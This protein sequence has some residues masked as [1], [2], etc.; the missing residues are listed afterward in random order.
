M[1]LRS[2]N[3]ARSDARRNGEQHHEQRDPTPGR[4]H[5]RPNSCTSPIVAQ[6]E[7]AISSPRDG[8]SETRLRFLSG[9]TNSKSG[10]TWTTTACVLTQA[11]RAN[12]GPCLV[13]RGEKGK[14]P[15]GGLKCP[16]LHMSRSASAKRPA[17]TRTGT[18]RPLLCFV[19][20]P[21]QVRRAVP[22]AFSP[23][24]CNGGRTIRAF[25]IQ[26]INC[27]ERPDLAEKLGAEDRPVIGRRREPEGARP[28]GRRE[29]VQ[30]HRAAARAVARRLGRF[31]RRRRPP[32]LRSPSRTRRRTSS[33]CRTPTRTRA[34]TTTGRGRRRPRAEAFAGGTVRRLAPQDD[35]TRR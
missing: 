31:P 8:D 13:H 33:T 24:F 20:S 35:G 29:R 14:R 9:L 3:G 7:R 18:A 17:E 12:R 4:P 28:P 19:Y 23:R 15:L 2:V 32:L 22:K 26:R 25:V 34:K 21:T 5:G 27:D 10:N 30:E 16:C 6:M 11:R 1:P